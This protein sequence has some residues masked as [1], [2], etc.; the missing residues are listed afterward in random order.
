VAFQLND[1]YDGLFGKSE[2]TGKENL[3]D[4]RDGKF[5]L[6]IQQGLERGNDEQR[7]TLTHLLGNREATTE[8]LE[9]VRDILTQ[10]G[11]AD[12]VRDEAR[13]QAVRDEAR[14]QAA[15]AAKVARDGIDIWGEAFAKELEALAQTILGSL[16]R[17]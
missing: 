2:V 1:D 5:T 3:D 4:I 15:V 13:K 14:K 16:A 9:T 10:T 17:G 6:L 12:Y 8:D 11:A 7:K